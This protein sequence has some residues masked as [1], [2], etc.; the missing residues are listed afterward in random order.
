VT[1]SQTGEQ[2]VQGTDFGFIKFGSRV[3]IFLPLDAKIN[4][5]LEQISKGNRTVIATFE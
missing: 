5:E 1:Y 3:D 4:V 2:V